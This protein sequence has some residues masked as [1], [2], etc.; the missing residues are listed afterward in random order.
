[1]PVEG[2]QRLRR[3][4][5][6]IPDEV[7]AEVKKEI[8]DG[9]ELVK[10]E[11]LKRVPVRDGTLA[12]SIEIWSG[13]DGLVKMI[14]PGAKTRRAKLQ[15]FYAKW[16]EFGTRPH[17]LSRGSRLAQPK[18]NRRGK[19]AGGAQHP[20]TKPR[21]FIHPAFVAAKS[22]FRPRINAAIDRAL[23]RVAGGA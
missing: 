7:T 1:M 11:M 12:A 15:A 23:K 17:S 6:R 8:D 16:V 10:F 13:K 20:G 5:N 21:P 22:K 2:T 19:N 9:A 3:L 14:G 4:L 18:R